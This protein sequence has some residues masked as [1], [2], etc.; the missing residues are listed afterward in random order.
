M[1]EQP[2]APPANP[3]PANPAAAAPAQP[4][5]PAPSPVA[6]APALPP[7]EQAAIDRIVRATRRVVAAH[8]RSDSKPRAR[9]DVHPKT[10]ATLAA[11]FEIVDEAAFAA[12]EQQ[13]GVDLRKGV[14][15]PGQ[16]YKAWVRFSNSSKRPQPD[17]EGDGRGLA[18]KLLDVT[19]RPRLLDAPEAQK[20]TQ[21][22]LLLS[23]PAFFAKDVHEMAEI[24]ELEAK[25][26][27]PSS[28]FRDSSRV[29][30][31]TALLQTAALKPASVLSI[32]YF[33]QT[34]YR[35]DALS[36]KY[37]VK[38]EGDVA[39]FG[40]FD[41]NAAEYKDP[42]YLHR[43]LLRMLAE[44][45]QEATFAFGVQLG[46]PDAQGNERPE[47]PIDDATRVWEETDAPFVK[48]ATLRIAPQAFDGKTRLDFAEHMTF[49]PWNGALPH[50]PLGSL[51]RARREAYRA[52]SIARHTLNRASE[53]EYSS[54]EWERLRTLQEPDA[55]KPLEYPKLS[56][57]GRA[58]R[59]AG[60]I[61]PT[62]LQRV[63]RFMYEKLTA[64]LIPVALWGTIVLFGTQCDAVS[65]CKPLLIGANLPSD[66]LIPAAKYSPHLADK[67]FAT[68]LET[69]KR[70]IVW[71]FR[72]AP[73]GAEATGGTP[74]WIYRVMPSLFPKHFD[75]KGDYSKFGLE[76]PDDDDYYTSY[77]ELPRGLVLSDTTLHIGG[78]DVGFRLKRVSFNCA[79]CHRGEYL[80]TDGPRVLVDGMPNSNIDTSGFKLAMFSAMREPGFN[81]TRVLG[82]IDE[83][84][85]KERA[86][87]GIPGPTKLTP[88]ERFIYKLV[89]AESKRF[90]QAKPLEWITKRPENG[91]GR[92]DAFGALRF[93]FMGH[94]PESDDTLAVVDLPSIWN[95]GT[96]MRPYHHYDGNTKHTRARNF[97]AIVG[98][99][100]IS[101][102]IHTEDVVRIGNW[103]DDGLTAPPYPFEIDRA[104]AEAGEKIYVKQCSSCHGTYANSTTVIGKYSADGGARYARTL[105]KL[106][107][108]MQKPED[109]KTD[110]Q[111]F[112]LMD[113]QFVGD[114]NELGRKKGL[115]ESTAFIKQPPGYLCPPLDGLWARAPFLHNGSV[116]TVDA[117]L[118]P[119]GQRPPKFVRGN[120]AYDREKLGFVDAAPTDRTSFVLDTAEVG[121]TN[122]GHDAQGMVVTDETQRKQ[123]IAYLSTL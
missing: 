107:D 99:G 18:I 78:N 95:Q 62:L 12:I 64:F 27:F 43:N 65:F 94:D 103:L 53:P 70:D 30:G 88:V 21:D 97:G 92:L 54:A 42:E 79:T 20:N 59:L 101:Y 60:A 72:Y 51:N 15:I 41:A 71:L 17:T 56:P 104:Q 76:K 40:V 108:C 100:G 5:A 67:P 110:E 118:L 1:A 33:S 35:L 109:V 111:R 57:M 116:P 77:H 81:E 83:L 24:A 55:W 74:Y 84:I 93:E 119:A 19:A 3:V 13:H 31:L 114:L 2:P 75:H 29:R 112:R 10:I 11:T 102:S 69:R 106:T 115:W 63:H 117:L 86:R 46:G 105:T 47:C 50:W 91:L 98:T 58:A 4:A 89:I 120:P 32:P 39:R 16:T 7:D 85:A 44:S 52:S 6:P 25:D 34:P 87:T 66:D 45:P 23:H 8:Y 22:F 123:L 68:D 37:A 122:L 49:N 26:E 80:R 73:T 36:V 113:A 48:L 38:P 121:N 96:N 9:R 82:A 61:A 90:A 14:F 28:F